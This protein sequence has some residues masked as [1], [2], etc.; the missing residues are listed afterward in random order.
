MT[1][2]FVFILIDNASI[3]GTVKLGIFLV[4]D[5][6]YLTLEHVPDIAHQIVHLLFWSSFMDITR[7]IIS[8]K[9]TLWSSVRRVY[10]DDREETL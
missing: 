7:S 10:M 6:H 8:S 4:K 2:L 1:Y 5:I 3:D 9:L